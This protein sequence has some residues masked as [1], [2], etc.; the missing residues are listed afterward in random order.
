[1]EL[2]VGDV[3]LCTVDRI[4]G[5]VVFVKIDGNGEGHII[6]SE[7]AP[8]RIRNL[9]DYVVPKKKI[10]CKVLRIKGNNIDL[11]LR[12]VTS[13]ER[14]EIMQQYKQEQQAKSAIHQLLKDKAEKT[15]TKILKDFPSL[16]E[17]F[18]K[19]R[20][21]PK[22]ITKYIPKQAQEQITKITQKKRKEIQVTKI[23]NLKCTQ[24]D[25]VKK[26]KKIFEIK[27]PNLKTTYISAGKFQITLK[28]KDYKQAKK[29][30]D[31]IV[32]QL[33]K[34]AKQNDC[35]FEVSEKKQK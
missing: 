26:I 34:S 31:K 15:E 14:K 19:A 28:G 11:S 7:I 30:I 6:T 23:I 22:L 33:E 12:R 27:N 5:T 35:E 32:E 1:M 8:G 4:V 25:G 3:V 9:R 2:E 21:N 29:E 17:F 13:K 24:D 20:E 18:N 10:V 16:S